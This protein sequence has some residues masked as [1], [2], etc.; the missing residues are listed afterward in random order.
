MCRFFMILDHVQI[1]HFLPEMSVADNEGLGFYQ[2]GAG[3]GRGICAGRLRLRP[4]YAKDPR[5]NKLVNDISL[6]LTSPERKRRVPAGEPRRLRSGLVSKNRPVY[7][8]AALYAAEP[9]QLLRILR[10]TSAVR[11]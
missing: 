1:P 8:C 9:Q 6:S 11:V 7:S 4:F 5:N 2:M 3:V 10:R